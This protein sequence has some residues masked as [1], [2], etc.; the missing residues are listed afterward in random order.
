MTAKNI[1]EQRIAEVTAQRLK[2]WTTAKWQDAS[3]AIADQTFEETARQIRIMCNSH[4]NAHLIA[5]GLSET[6]LRWRGLLEHMKDYD[7]RSAQGAAYAAFQ[8]AATDLRIACEALEQTGG[9][10]WE[11]EAGNVS[12]HDFIGLFDSIGISARRRSSGAKISGRPT[13]PWSNLG[14]IV[15]E[16]VA[17]MLKAGGYPKNLR[18][19]RGVV[20]AICTEIVNHLFKMKISAEGFARQM[21]PRDRRRAK[22]GSRALADLVPDIARVKVWSDQKP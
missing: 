17:N 21:N 9:F 14:G 19:D 11:R 4:N 3:K 16:L 5:S 7:L 20:P 12:T 13:A 15:A 18:R 10:V 2:Q 8:R 1:G 22:G 6:P